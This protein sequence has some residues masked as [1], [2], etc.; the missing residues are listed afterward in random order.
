MGV[1]FAACGKP[2]EF[3]K[4][5]IPVSETV[6]EAETAAVD[7]VPVTITEPVSEETPS[8]TATRRRG[9]QQNRNPKAKA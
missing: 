9:T 1:C 7:A 4:V 8:E 3:E 6:T 5:D 2:T